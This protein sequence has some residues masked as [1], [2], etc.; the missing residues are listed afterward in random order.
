M[1]RSSQVHGLAAVVRPQHAETTDK[2]IA[3]GLAE[4]ELI[5]AAELLPAR[6]V[7]NADGDDALAGGDGDK[8]LIP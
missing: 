2:L 8:V 3:N 7:F 6:L 1:F 4:D 5:D